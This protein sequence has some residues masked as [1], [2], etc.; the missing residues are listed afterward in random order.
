MQVN[1]QGQ[2][3]I[4]AEVQERLGFAPGTEIELEIVGE[5]LEIRKKSR[6]GSIKAW[7]ERVK[8]TSTSG[9]TTDEIMQLTRGDD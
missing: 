1:E 5:K 7:I 2:V 6:T 8:G 4:P 3:T 9:M